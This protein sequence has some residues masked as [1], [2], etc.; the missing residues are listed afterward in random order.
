MTTDDSTKKMLL[1]IRRTFGGGYGPTMEE[2]K[3]YCDTHPDYIPRC[4]RMRYLFIYK[5]P[6]LDP[7]EV[8]FIYKKI[9]GRDS[10]GEEICVDE[11]ASFPAMEIIRNHVGDEFDSTTE[12]IDHCLRDERFLAEWS[13]KFLG[14]HGC[15]GKKTAFIMDILLNAAAEAVVCKNSS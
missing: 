11:T 8:Y 1:K 5:N 13:D 4:G 10:L 15:A 3:E 7:L 12:L 2:F 14:T 6:E 9:I